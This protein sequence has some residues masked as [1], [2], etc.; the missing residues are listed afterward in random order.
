MRAWVTA[1]MLTVVACSVSSTISGEGDGAT[2]R[3]GVN[4]LDSNGKL[5][6]EEIKKVNREY[7]SALLA[8]GND[9][10][11]IKNAEQ[12]YRDNLPMRSFLI[13]D[14][15][16]DYVV[17]L[18]EFE[19]WYEIDVNGKGKIS[20]LPKL[21][22]KDVEVYGAFKSEWHWILLLAF[23]NDKDKRIDEK[24]FSAYMI[25]E[26]MKAAGYKAK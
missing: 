10:K 9:S 16:D 26:E 3:F 25:A 4:D 13:A 5:E 15:N 17:T 20:D 8:A 14:A 19:A 6:L 18:N 12:K 22:E 23:D 1:L 21:S 11:A 7:R 24:E 2:A